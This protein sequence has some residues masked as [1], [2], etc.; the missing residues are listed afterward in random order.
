MKL[1]LQNL[2]LPFG[3]S[4]EIKTHKLKD[5]K[6]S[7]FKQGSFRGWWPVEGNSKGKKNDNVYEPSLTVKINCG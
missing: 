5:E 3:N 7:L 4:R 1:D 2:P 6:R